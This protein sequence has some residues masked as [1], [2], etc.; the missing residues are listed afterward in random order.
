MTLAFTIGPW[1]GFY[2]YWGF[3][4]RLCLGWVAITFLPVDFDALLE[5]KEYTQ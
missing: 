3:S 4:K 5:D 2:C 1:G